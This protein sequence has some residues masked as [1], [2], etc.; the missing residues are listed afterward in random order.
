MQYNIWGF[1]KAFG[2]ILRAKQIELNLWFGA[3]KAVKIKSH[4]AKKETTA[5]RS[6]YWKYISNSMT[7]NV[8][9]RV[10]ARCVM[11]DER[12]LEDA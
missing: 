5:T 3:H 7:R 11:T 8:T 6:K 9:P 2:Q 12:T 4:T 1:C 10:H